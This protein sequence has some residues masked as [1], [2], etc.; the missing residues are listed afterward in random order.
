MCFFYKVPKHITLNDVIMVV[1][2]GY[3]PQELMGYGILRPP[4]WVKSDSLFSLSPTCLLPGSKATLG[5]FHQR[6]KMKFGSFA[7]FKIL[8]D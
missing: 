2:L 5:L 3:E 8:I 6:L 7:I 1:L 4:L